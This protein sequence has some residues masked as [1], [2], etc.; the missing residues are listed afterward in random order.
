MAN[1]QSLWKNPTIVAALIAAF[2]AIIVALIQIL[3]EQDDRPKTKTEVSITPRPNISGI[4][5]GGTGRYTVTQDGNRVLWDGIGR[6]GNKVW[7]H[8]GK[9]TI[10]G[11]TITARIY[12]QPDS[13]FPGIKGG[14]R[15]EG[16]IAADMQTISWTGQNPQERIWRRSQ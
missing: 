9:G 1:K 14:A 6:Y 3:P 4:W 10:E 15:T 5:I 11:D 16:S 13:Y 7:H 8:K 12:E 2:T